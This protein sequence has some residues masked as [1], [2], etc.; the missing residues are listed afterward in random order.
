MKRIIFSLLSISIVAMLFLNSCQNDRETLNMTGTMHLSITDAPIDKYDITGV[1]ITVNEV[2]IHKQGDN[3]QVIEEFEGPVTYNLLELT[4]GISELMAST[5]LTAGEY[6]QIRF[7]L[8]APVN[9]GPGNIANPGCYLMFAD[10]STTPLFVPSGGQ[11]GYKATGK[12]AVPANGE[13]HVVADFDVRKS[14]V[15]AGASGKF[16]LK[17]TIRLVTENQAGAIA[18]TLLNLEEDYSAVIYAYQEGTYQPE[19]ADLPPDEETPRFPNAVS[20]NA[21]DEEGNFIIPFLAKGNYDLVVTSTVDGEFHAVLGIIEG[22]EVESN[23]TTN[24][25]IDVEDF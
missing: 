23:K 9:Q 7:L 4:N 17:P 1:F 12:F 2:Q 6:T 25:I 15:V 19:E 22:I 11:S 5:V 3:W 18:G 24:I 10:G 20:S 13:V 16:I 14:I 21:I 8:D